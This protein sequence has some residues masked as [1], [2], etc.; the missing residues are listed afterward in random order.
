MERVTNFRRKKG[1]VDRHQTHTY[2]E[3]ERLILEAFKESPLIAPNE[4]ELTQQALELQRRR[5][6]G[7][8][9]GE[10]QRKI[11]R[12]HLKQLLKKKRVLRTGKRYVMFEALF[13]P[14]QEFHKKVN[15][16]LRSDH[17]APLDFVFGHN[18]AASYLT[19]MPEL[20]KGR[21]AVTELWEQE[22]VRFA[23]GLFGL[24]T[25][26]VY[27]IK[28]GYISS[29]IRSQ[30]GIDVAALR[31][32]L[33][34]SLDDLELFILSFAVDVPQLLNYLSTHAGEK[35]VSRILWRE[36]GAIMKQAE[37]TSVIHDRGLIINRDT[38]EFRGLLSR[39]E[40]LR[41]LSKNTGE[42]KAG[43]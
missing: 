10:I 40:R 25:L 37:A 31:E 30:S 28:R 16:L 15:S 42:N 19:T 33:K 20:S 41:L 11:V 27:A 17:I 29:K 21:R 4:T 2:S 34:R 23:K 24:R 1:L 5:P 14:S 32:G 12:K 6:D 26:V 38:A 3:Y 18:A 43:R 22:A 36:W 13:G 8:W 39:S 35:L 9:R 7:P